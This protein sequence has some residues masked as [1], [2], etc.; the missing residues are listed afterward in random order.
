MKKIII[1]V[2]ALF[3][4]FTFQV[5]SRD[6][7]VDNAKLLNNTQKNNITRIIDSIS[8]LYNFDLVI[9][10]ET[11]IGNKAP[12]DYA[13]DFYDNNGYGFGGNKD[14]CI[15]LQVTGSRDYWVSTCGRGIELFNLFIGNKLLDD[16]LKFLKADN[17][18]EA[19]YSFINNWENI[20]KKEAESN[21]LFK[22]QLT[23]ALG[24]SLAEEVTRSLDNISVKI[25]S[26][27]TDARNDV[28][29]RKRW[30]E[31]LTNTEELF[32]KIFNNRS[33]PYT[34]F[35]S[36]GIKQ[37]K[38]NYQ[39]ETVEYSTSLNL[40]MNNEWVSILDIALK[41]VKKMDDE[42]QG[43]GRRSDWGLNDWPNVGVSKTN[44]FS[45]RY[46][47]G[48]FDGV[49][50]YG[51]QWK[52]DFSI[53]FELLN[54]K[55]KVIGRQTFSLSPF[56]EIYCYNRN[57]YGQF[58]EYG[59]SG[60]TIV[61]SE[62]AIRLNYDVNNIKTLTFSNVKVNET[63]D[64]MTI[65]IVSVNGNRPE[66]AKTKIISLSDSQWNAYDWR[67]KQDPLIYFR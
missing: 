57:F 60:G 8:I 56:F 22:S 1:I 7:I 25:T 64:I 45:T 43:T 28:T 29:W 21:E 30:V 66:N 52:T 37:G 10:T 9:V 59:R 46:S 19:Y 65:R 12:R 62:R 23:T 51:T 17:P 11:D 55:N 53:V 42:L 44:P 2:I 40:R 16:I 39:T 36:T 61:D 20:L 34:L 6:R 26:E 67:E 49:Q 35:Y 5:F 63:S 3:L 27:G 47:G 50:R 33:L 32:F 31:R 15:L 54:D 48:G 18:Y 24:K 58:I 14:G 13:D 38:I 41:T 4:L